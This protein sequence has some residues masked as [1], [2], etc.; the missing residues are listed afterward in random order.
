MVL[1]VSGV[2][3]EVIVKWIRQRSWS[4]LIGALLIC[5]VN[6]ETSAGLLTEARC[7]DLTAISTPCSTALRIVSLWKSQRLSPASVPADIFL[8]WCRYRR[9][10]EA[11]RFLDRVRILA[12][13]FIERGG[14]DRFKNPNSLRDVWPD[15]A[16]TVDGDAWGKP[17]SMEKVELTTFF[18]STGMP[19]LSVNQAPEKRPIDQYP[20][21]ST[22]ADAFADCVWSKS[23]WSGKL[24]DPGKGT[25][26]TKARVV[27]GRAGTAG[28]RWNPIAIALALNEG[29]RRSHSAAGP[30]TGQ[31][32][33]TK[34]YET[35]RVRKPRLAHVFE[36]AS[37][38]HWADEW[39]ETANL[40]DD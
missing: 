2:T 36:K 24:K 35:R 15:L 20:S 17:R 1:L 3:D 6:P 8:L 19:V 23:E 22:I 10:E 18:P 14:V 5:N 29:V 11:D 27:S 40:L 32:D 34:K 9:I 30:G 26:L 28:S 7:E 37:L 16:N 4:P 38:S 39:A 25:W 33:G 12:P 13:K 21:S 31:S